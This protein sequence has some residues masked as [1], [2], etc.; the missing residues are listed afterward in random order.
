MCIS[1]VESAKFVQSYI[2]QNQPIL[3][4]QNSCLYMCVCVVQLPWEEENYKSFVYPDIKS[5]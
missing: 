3:I 1:K 2:V 5:M 4:D